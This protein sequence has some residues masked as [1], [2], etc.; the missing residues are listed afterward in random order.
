MKTPGYRRRRVHRLGVRPPGACAAN[1]L[2]GVVNLD[3][4]T[5]AGNLENL[6]A[7]G[8]DPPLPL[9]AR[10]YLRRG[11]RWTPLF[12]GGE[13]RRHRALRRRIARGPQHP[14]ARA[15]DSDQPARHVHAARSR[16]PPR[17][18]PL[19]ARFHRRSLRQPGARRSKPTRTS[20]CNPAARIRR[21]R[22]ARTCWR[23]P[24]SSPTSCRW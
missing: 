19:P 5:Y 15:G 7:G 13:A 9:R 21:P 14:L 3:K 8:S 10:R 22:P 24:T 16:A 20:R 6:A 11:A 1:R 4:L 17:H 23:A 18:R 2:A 12:A